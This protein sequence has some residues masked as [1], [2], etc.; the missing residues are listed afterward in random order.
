MVRM[1]EGVESRADAKMVCTAASLSGMDSGS[2]FLSKRLYAAVLQSMTMMDR[3]IV[4]AMSVSCA[5]LRASFVLLP[6]SNSPNCKITRGPEGLL[7]SR[8]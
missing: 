3:L 8:V 5:A 2:Y 6:L 4:L 7:L 1:L